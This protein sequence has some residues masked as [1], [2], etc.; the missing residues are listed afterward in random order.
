MNKTGFSG[1]AA[2]AAIKFTACGAIVV[3]IGAAVIFG[4]NVGPYKVF[5]Y[6]VA[7]G[8]CVRLIWPTQDE[9]DAL[10]KRDDG[11]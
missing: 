1:N 8:V 10:I 3:F 4:D 9:G 7:G 2:R 6:T 5:L 11:P